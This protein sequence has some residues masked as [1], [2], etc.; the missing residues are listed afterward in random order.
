MDSSERRENEEQERKKTYG[1][2]GKGE[3]CSY[4]AA[5]CDSEILQKVSTENAFRTES[6]KWNAASEEEEYKGWGIVISKR[7]SHKSWIVRKFL[8]NLHQVPL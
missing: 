5:Y 3:L 4:R 6:E 1:W 8:F 7:M 2:R